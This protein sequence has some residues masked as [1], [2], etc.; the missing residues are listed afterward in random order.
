MLPSW[1]SEKVRFVPFQIDQT[2]PDNDEM[3]QLG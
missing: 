3:A 1:V 2:R